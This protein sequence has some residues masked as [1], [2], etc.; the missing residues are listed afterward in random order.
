MLP[1]PKAE[2]SY[3]VFAVSNTCKVLLQSPQPD[4]VHLE[5]LQSATVIQYLVHSMEEVWMAGVIV[6]ADDLLLMATYHHTVHF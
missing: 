5:S 4:P 1:L 6:P 3:H 2:E